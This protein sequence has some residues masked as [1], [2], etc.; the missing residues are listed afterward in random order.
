M[1]EHHQPHLPMQPNP[2][3]LPLLNLQNH[4]RPDSNRSPR[5]ILLKR[6][7]GP[8]K[9]VQTLPLNTL[10]KVF[11]FED[12]GATAGRQR[13][14]YIRKVCRSNAERKNK[15]YCPWLWGKAIK[16]DGGT[17]GPL[18]VSPPSCFPPPPS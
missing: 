9:S 17:P 6:R 3:D 12:Q 1:A 7:V 15:I 13:K 5:L 16:A 4:A 11:N 8:G 2:T 14:P 10:R 18:E